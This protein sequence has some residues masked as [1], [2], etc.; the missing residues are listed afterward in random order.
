MPAPCVDC[1]D[2]SAPRA[3]RIGVKDIYS[4]SGYTVWLSSH[5]PLA[6]AQLRDA[7]AQNPTPTTKLLLW[8]IHRLRA[9]VLRAN[10]LVRSV[11]TYDRGLDSTTQALLKGLRAALANEPVVREDEARRLKG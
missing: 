2:D 9:L 5:Q 3:A 7:W 8:E 4:R 6:R 10:D 1:S 11:S